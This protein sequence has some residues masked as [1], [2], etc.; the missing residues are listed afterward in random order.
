MNH[1]RQ[2]AELF[3]LAIPAGGVRASDTQTALPLL[4]G[5]GSIHKTHDSGQTQP[6]RLEFFTDIA[7]TSSKFTKLKITTLTNHILTSCMLGKY[8][9]SVSRLLKNKTITELFLLSREQ[10][11]EGPSH[12]HASVS[13][14]CRLTALQ[15]ENK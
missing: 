7:S 13:V 12:T 15:T 4:Q 9:T 1:L 11:H 8:E 10:L 5:E 6:A 2:K 3:L 14:C